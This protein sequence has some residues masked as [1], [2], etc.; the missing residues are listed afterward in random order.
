MTDYVRAILD[1]Q[2]NEWNISISKDQFLVS[3]RILERYSWVPNVII[4]SFASFRIAASADDKSWLNTGLELSEKYNP[5][6]AWNQWELDSLTA[7]GED[8]QWIESINSFWDQHFPF[9]M[10][11]KNSYSFF[12]IRQ[13]DGAIVHGEEPLFEDTSVI[14]QDLQDCLKKLSESTN[15][16]T[17][18][19]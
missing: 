12:A 5:S 11:V 19:I 6:Y 2:K 16:Y 14:A 13:S 4:N 10:S 7:A 8:I 1:L 15:M 18:L 9:L 3:T 17:D